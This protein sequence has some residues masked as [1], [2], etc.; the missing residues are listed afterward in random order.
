MVHELQVGAGGGLKKAQAEKFVS[1]FL[2][3]TLPIRIT[4]N[5]FSC[6]VGAR[7]NRHS[8][9]PPSVHTLEQT[10]TVAVGIL[11]SRMSPDRLPRKPALRHALFAG[12]LLVLVFGAMASPVR[13]QDPGPLAPP[14]KFEVN[15]IPSVPH[16]G[17]PPIP[18]EQIIQRFA[19]S[20]D[21]A[22]KIYNTYDFSQTIRVEEVNNPDGSAGAGGKM[23][24]TGEDY[25]HP[26]GQR[27]WRATKPTE[28]S[29]T[30]PML[31]D[32]LHPV[33]SLPLFFL[34]TAEIG[35]YNFLYAGQDKLDDL[36]TY[37]FQVKPKQVSRSRLYFEGAVWVDD[38]DLAIVK[39]FGKF[40][41]ETSDNSTGLPFN[42][43][44]MY[45][46]NFQ[47]KYWLPTYIVSDAYVDPGKDDELHLRLVLRSSGFKLN[48]LAGPA[49]APTPAL[50]PTNVPSATSG[51]SVPATFPDDKNAGQSSS[52]PNSDTP[53]DTIHKRIN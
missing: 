39:T 21:V 51:A 7:S 28:S 1:Q 37:V 31:L 13:A 26:D 47:Q 5:S 4:R 32:D 23:V 43:F 33:M 27:F 3:D 8:P 29:L 30:K 42:M 35:N 17:P 14:P 41:S 10:K 45:R 34:T 12:M 25:V 40:V 20:E 38:H 52:S 16:P 18:V 9:A 48:S 11:S 50:A 22:Q 15:R 6:S 46:E 19:A 2:I 53:P 24:A 44:E 49:S 36:N